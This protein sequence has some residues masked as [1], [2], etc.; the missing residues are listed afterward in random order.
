MRKSIVMVIAGALL[1]VAP[2][3]GGP[4]MKSQVA[5]GANWVVHS[6]YEQFNR[7]AVGQLFR[8]ELVAIGVEE[9]LINFETVFSFHPLDDV[10]DVTIYGQGQDQKKAVVL[11]DG[12]FD[13]EKLLALVKMNPEYEEI[14]HGGITVHKWRQEGK[15]GS[16]PDES[17]LMYGC[18]YTDQLVVISAGLDTVKQA[19]DIL[20]GR[21]MNA[22]DVVFSHAI[23]D[24]EGV[25]CQVMAYNVS[26]TAGREPKAAVLRQTDELGLAVGENQG[27]VFVDLGLTAESEQTAQAIKKVLDGIVAFVALTGDE[28][29]RLAALAQNVQTSC[30]QSTVRAHLE[31]DPE[32]IIQ[33]LKEQW[34]KKQTSAEK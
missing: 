25:F 30:T 11:I 28:Q 21:A 33:L 6:D 27:K 4:L 3:L 12:I 15:P 18:L 9:K 29:P 10:R 23:P 26:A 5:A 19:V 14:E 31:S 8:A 20:Q 2:A 32:S 22:T 17:P 16:G 7:S 13:T 24:A 1:A 34:Q